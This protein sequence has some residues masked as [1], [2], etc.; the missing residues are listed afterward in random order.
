MTKRND[1]MAKLMNAGINTNKYFTINLPNGLNANS[2]I[3][4]MIDE[5][6]IPVPVT[7]DE[8]YRGIIADGYVRNTKLH[9]RFVMAQMFKMLNYKSYCGRGEGYTYYLNHMYSYMYQFTM[10]CDELK[11]LAKLEKRDNESF[12]ERK[13]FFTKSVIIA[14]MRDYV[15]KAQKV[16]NEMP[17]KKCKGVPYKKLKKINVFVSDLYKKVYAPIYT[18]I[19]AMI[20]AANYESMYRT[21]KHF[22][23]RMLVAIP[24]NE[25]KCVEWV[26]AF[27]GAGAFYTMKNMFMYHK[28]SIHNGS[29]ILNGQH[30]VCYIDSLVNQYEGQGWRLLGVL[31]EVIKFNNFD[32]DKRMKEIYG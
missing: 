30:A 29:D 1:R 11:V 28:C 10:T 22:M 19:D 20:Q 16:I 26:D 24:Y 13:R 18:D 17:T 23:G 27:K 25:T 14:L 2:Q 32:F 12:N 6:G 7:E 9:R 8:M 3:R 31:K 4:I 5:N 15:I 21:F